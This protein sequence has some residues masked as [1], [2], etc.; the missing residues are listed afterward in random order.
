MYPTRKKGLALALVVVLAVSADAAD[1][2]GSW[3]AEFTAPDFSTRPCR[4]TS[5][6]LA[7]HP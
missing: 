7:R 5:H 2:T 3:R 6:S 4:E 1:V